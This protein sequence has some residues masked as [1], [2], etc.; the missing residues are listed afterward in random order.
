MVET[1]AFLRLRGISMIANLDN[2][3]L[4]SPSLEHLVQDLQV[5][6]SFS[7]NLGW[8]LNLVQSNLVPSQWV[9][10]LGYILDSTQRKVFLK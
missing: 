9:T 10:F 6:L 2:L 3:L 4:F 7:E 1:L 5:A 8:P